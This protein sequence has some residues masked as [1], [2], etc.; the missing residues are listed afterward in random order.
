M[1]N[2]ADICLH[3]RANLAAFNMIHFSKPEGCPILNT[4]GNIR[5]GFKAWRW[6]RPGMKVQ[7]VFRR[8]LATCPVMA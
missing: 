5:L 8:N 7:L 4:L 1:V 6:K 2:L 3:S